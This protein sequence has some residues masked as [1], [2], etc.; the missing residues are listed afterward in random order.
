M[1]DS[2]ATA[3]NAVPSASH[4]GPPG[5]RHSSGRPTPAHKTERPRA[6][7]SA[8]ARPG[9]PPAPPRCSPRR[10]GTG[11]EPQ[12]WGVCAEPQPPAPASAPRASRL[13]PGPVWAL[14]GPERVA[15][16]PG[17]ASPTLPL[18]QRP[19]GG[20]S[21]AQAVARGCR[22]ALAQTTRGATSLHAGATVA[23]V[24]CLAQPAA[25]ARAHTRA[26]VA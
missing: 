21:R 12:P 13:S 15:L 8:P 9:R 14:Y 4:H 16:P 19:P 7:G 2:A 1:R 25:A 23:I 20:A 18:R 5:Y 10:G 11:P 17:Y 6:P 22:R 24:D 26:R 3:Q